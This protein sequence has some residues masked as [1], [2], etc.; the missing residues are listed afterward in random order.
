MLYNG[1]TKFLWKFKGVKLTC[2]NFTAVVKSNS[3]AVEQS[4]F[5]VVEQ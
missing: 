5:I 4:K 1:Q 2:L 3:I